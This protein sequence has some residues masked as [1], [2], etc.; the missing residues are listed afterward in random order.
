MS[1]GLKYSMLLCCFFYRY[2][3][4]FSKLTSLSVWGLPSFLATTLLTML[5]LR[6]YTLRPTLFVDLMVLA[7]SMKLIGMIPFIYTWKR[8]QILATNESLSSSYLKYLSMFNI[9]R[10]NSSQNIVLIMNCLLCEKKKKL[11]DLP[12]DSPAFL[13]LSKFFSG[14]KLSMIMLLVMPSSNLSLWNDL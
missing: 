1:F 14:F 6:S 4:Q 13:A 9:N 12:V 5:P 2:F 8:P 10:S 7:M 11:P 3:L